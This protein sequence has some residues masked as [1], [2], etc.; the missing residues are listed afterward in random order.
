MAK[1]A[2]IALPDP[3]NAAA[4]AAAPTAQSTL[5]AQS[6]PTAAA[7]AQ[8]TLTAKSTAAAATPIAKSTAAA[9]APTGPT[10]IALSAQVPGRAPVKTRAVA[11]SGEG[12]GEGET[13]ERPRRHRDLA[14]PRAWIL[15]AQIAISRGDW[16]AARNA[17]REYDQSTR[18]DPFSNA[19]AGILEAI[20]RGE[21]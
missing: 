1:A 13:S 21:K 18:D 7:T 16:E 5:A 15:H 8:S 9:A 20:A 12:Y 10:P 14:L 4:A 6:P 3:F 17:I 19:R 2:A 11:P